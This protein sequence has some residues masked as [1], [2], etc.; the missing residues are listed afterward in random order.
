MEDLECLWY[1]V[2]EK[3]GTEGCGIRCF[4]VIEIMD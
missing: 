1:E 3:R 2:T 4:V